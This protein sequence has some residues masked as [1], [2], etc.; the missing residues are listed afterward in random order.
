MNAASQIG[1]QAAT[2]ARLK[3]K[4]QNSCLKHKKA[5]HNLAKS[6]MDFWHLIEVNPDFCECRI[7]LSETN[8][9]RT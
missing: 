6:V 5:A 8:F 9:F 4:E 1:R 7:H 3:L 2:A